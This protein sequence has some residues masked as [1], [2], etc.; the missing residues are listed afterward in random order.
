MHPEEIAMNRLLCLLAL[1]VAAAFAQQPQPAPQPS[2][3]AQPEQPQPGQAL[4]EKW[5]PA[6]RFEIV[7]PH[8]TDQERYRTLLPFQFFPR[9]TR[10]AP[11]ISLRV[12]PSGNIIVP[13]PLGLP[14]KPCSLPL[15]R[16]PL[17]AEGNIQTI[18]PDK[19]MAPMPAVNL[20]APPCEQRR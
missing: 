18:A 10:R 20:P 6:P 14:S 16:V 1:P 5:R 3:Q 13:A 2:G 7:P 17:P 4:P 11:G 12:S 9:P 15:V 19:P 8:W